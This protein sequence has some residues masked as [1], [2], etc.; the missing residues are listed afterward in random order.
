MSNIHD[1]KVVSVTG[2]KLNTTCAEGKNHCHTMSKDAKI[3][4][5]GKDSKAADLKAGT[6]VRVTCHKDDK[7]V[8]TAVESGKHIATPVH[9]A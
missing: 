9:K 1:G 8:A 4:C 2:D 5:D 6:P 3:T 7:S